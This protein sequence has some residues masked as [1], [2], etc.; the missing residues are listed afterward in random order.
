MDQIIAMMESTK[1]EGLQVKITIQLQT[2]TRILTGKL[3]LLVGKQPYQKRI[4]K[5]YLIN[6]RRKYLNLYKFLNLMAYKI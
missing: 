6:Q 1:M 4:L 2:I 5:L 3:K